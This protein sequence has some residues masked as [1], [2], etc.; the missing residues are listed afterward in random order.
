VLRRGGASPEYIWVERRSP[1]TVKSFMFAIHPPRGTDVVSVRPPRS[2]DDQAA[3]R[4]LQGGER[5]PAGCRPRVVASRWWPKHNRTDSATGVAAQPAPRLRRVLG[6]LP[7]VSTGR[8]HRG[9]LV[10]TVSGGATRSRS[11]TPHR[12]AALRV[13]TRMWPPY[14]LIEPRTSSLGGRGA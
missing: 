1:T 7:G 4:G 3:R 12:R 13:W 5:G 11:S 8:A 2:G 14:L 10:T 9:Q 6:H